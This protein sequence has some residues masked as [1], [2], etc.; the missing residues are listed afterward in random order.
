[1]AAQ[2]QQVQHQ[3]PPNLFQPQPQSHFSP[4]SNSPSPNDEQQQALGFGH[5]Q[6]QA[7]NAS[8]AQQA[9]LDADMDMTGTDDVPMA[10][11]EP[12]PLTVTTTATDE[13][14]GNTMHLSPGPFAAA[15]ASSVAAPRMPTP[16]NP[17]FGSHFGGRSSMGHGGGTLAT[18]YRE[19]QQQDRAVPR[20][21]AS[22][23]HDVGMG[24][25]CHSG[26]A[27]GWVN[28]RL[29]SP[30]S[31]S[32]N[33]DLQ[34][35]S[36]DGAGDAMAHEMTRHDG[37]QS[38]H[39]LDGMWHANLQCSP[40]DVSMEA[41]EHDGSHLPYA[42]SHSAPTTPAGAP[43]HDPL[44]LQHQQHQGQQG[45]Q[46]DG[47]DGMSPEQRQQQQQ[48]PKRPG[49]TRSRHTLNSWTL[50]PGMKRSFSI[51]FRADCDKCRQKVPGHFN[52]II[53]S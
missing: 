7:A 45:Q 4:W 38:G 26:G 30:I 9:A 28:R 23:M 1:M 25:G 16:I 31:E 24:G 52:H 34:Q 5:G 22:A 39:R 33:E 48:M 50:Q 29:P 6:Q 11:A 15:E 3:Q 10:S 47:I 36:A 8:H 37:H 13:S 12:H 14:N 19:M 2:H 35:A 44:M 21:A 53:V 20:T 41:S 46:M 40:H 27:F 43:A 17:S 51:G 32:G 42:T 18:G 49:H